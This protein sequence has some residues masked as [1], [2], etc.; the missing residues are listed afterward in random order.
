[1]WLS[2]RLLHRSTGR[3][4]T[5]FTSLDLQR[6]WQGQS[7]PLSIAFDPQ[8]AP[9]CW[10]WSGAWAHLPAASP[11]P[12]ATC[13]ASAGFFTP[14]QAR[15]DGD[16]EADPRMLATAFHGAPPAW[17]SR[18]RFG[19]SQHCEVTLD[20]GG[21]GLRLLSSEHRGWGCAGWCIAP[22][23]PCPGQ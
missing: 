18:A 15:Q 16:V 5:L 8:R 4:T 22:C 10:G 9:T 2:I 14:T 7:P 11:F 12:R 1:M 20:F 19:F 3:A 23:R 13:S 17:M 21:E 6:D